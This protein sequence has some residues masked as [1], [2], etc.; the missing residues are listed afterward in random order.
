MGRGESGVFEKK[1]LL[2]LSKKI[3]GLNLNDFFM[4]CP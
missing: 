3:E 4:F 2:Y 1:Y